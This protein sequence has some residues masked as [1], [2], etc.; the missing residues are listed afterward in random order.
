MRSTRFTT[1]SGTTDLRGPVNVVAPGALPQREFA[2]AF[3]R[4]LH[5]PA[6][7]PLPEIA[8]RKIFGQMGEETLLAGHFVEPAV[9]R[10]SGFTWS[11]ADL[12]EA[13]LR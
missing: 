6:V 3:G 9:L 12:D 11:A 7:V 4:A 8:V 5:R 1:R 2:S 10:R 13:L